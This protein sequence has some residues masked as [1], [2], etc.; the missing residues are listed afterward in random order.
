[1]DRHELTLHHSHRD[2]TILCGTRRAAISARLVRAYLPAAL[3]ASSSSSSPTPLLNRR[4]QLDLDD[5]IAGCAP[6]RAGML[7][8]A[9]MQRICQE[10][11]DILADASDGSISSSSNG[12]TTAAADA[13]SAALMDALARAQLEDRRTAGRVDAAG[14]RGGGGG[15]RHPRTLSTFIALADLS[16]TFGSRRLGA[17]L[18][19][20]FA[21]HGERIVGTCADPFS[22]DDDDGDGEGA[23]LDLEG[24][25]RYDRYGGGGGRGHGDDGL[26]H[27]H[28][29]LLWAWSLA[30][31]RMASGDADRRACLRDLLRARPDV[32]LSGR[33]DG[34]TAA[35][36]PDGDAEELWMAVERAMEREGGRR[37]G[38]GGL[39]PPLG[40]Q[41][42][43][44]Q[45]RRGFEGFFEGRGRK[46]EMDR[47]LQE[48]RR[49]A[50]GGAGVYMHE[51]RE[52]RVVRS[53]GLDG[54]DRRPPPPLGLETYNHC[55]HRHIDPLDDR[56]N[57]WKHRPR[58][59]GVGVV[60]GAAGRLRGTL[61]SIRTDQRELRLDVHDVKDELDE[62][63]EQVNKL[64]RRDGMRWRK[65]RADR[66]LADCCCER[67]LPE[68]H[69]SEWVSEWWDDSY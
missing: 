45:Q 65:G 24:Y 10:F 1:M 60:G 62:L 12:T 6:V 31:A 15:V 44:Q 38:G 7:R 3:L 41:Q 64:G 69:E 14:H 67:G 35:A 28:A 36:L 26:E 9:K 54:G 55:A 16:R 13:V 34:F 58:G 17:V 27:P 20:F 25:D 22:D 29:V 48:R 61:D 32:L 30:V 56:I 51:H 57:A 39:W 46:R 8:P 37:G 49:A 63:V 68:E 52:R 42:Q 66:D 40:W 4:N 33:Y 43:Q 21:R 19:A 50:A 5:H 11:V 59:Y 53:S 23:G 2:V 18:S 47:D